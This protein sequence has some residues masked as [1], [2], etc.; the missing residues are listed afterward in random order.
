M[1][2]ITKI[3]T[4][5]FKKD[6]VEY[7]SNWTETTYLLLMKLLRDDEEENENNTNKLTRNQN[8][9]IQVKTYKDEE[10]IVNKDA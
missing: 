1:N 3:I 7:T 9:K 10:L 5:T 8:R 2:E 6:N 4:N